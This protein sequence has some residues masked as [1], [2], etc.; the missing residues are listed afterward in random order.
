MIINELRHN[1]LRSLFPKKSPFCPLF[2]SFYETVASTVLLSSPFTSVP[3]GFC[4]LFSG[5]CPF[6]PLHVQ[7]DS[8]AD[9]RR[10]PYRVDASLGLPVATVTSL[11]RVARRREQ[12]VV[13]ERQRFLQIWREERGQGFPQ[14]P[15]ST[16]PL[17]QLVQPVER[18][19][20]PT[21]AVEQPV[22]LVHNL[23]QRPQLR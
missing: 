13:Q 20:R 5:S 14:P 4:R 1:K 2:G 3:Q 12:L 21:A 15:E 9:V 16:D 8:L 11:H 18:R 22:D 6:A 17:L 19:F 23:P 10:S 7:R